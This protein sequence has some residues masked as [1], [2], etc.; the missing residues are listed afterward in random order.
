[1]LAGVE[2]K[3]LTEREVRVHRL[4]N[5]VYPDAHLEVVLRAFPKF[6]EILRIF[7]PD[8][9]YWGRQRL[10]IGAFSEGE[11][12]GTIAVQNPNSQQA[13]EWS[14]AQW[15][16]FFLHFSHEELNKYDT[17]NTSLL[18][19]SLRA[20]ENAYLMH[21]LS[22][23]P[24]FRLTGLAT[25]LI[26]LAIAELSQNEKK[27]LFVE[28]ARHRYLEKLFSKHGFRVVRK[29]FSISEKLEYGQWGSILMRHEADKQ[30]Q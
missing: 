21:S 13:L 4:F 10:I 16:R 11:M 3:L 5:L 8:T 23:A 19:T 6:A 14:D 28:T 1:M 9:L 24:S 17:W 29:S 20:P 15:A 22:V 25:K 30:C 18:K 27:E 12:V 7:D 26:G 2:I